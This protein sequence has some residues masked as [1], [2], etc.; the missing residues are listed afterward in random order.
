MARNS[1]V[2]LKEY[3]FIP[4]SLPVSRKA[5]FLLMVYA[6]SANGEWII[7]IMFYRSYTTHLQFVFCICF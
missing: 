6:S 2:S 7:Y 5:E 1:L 4:F 3:L